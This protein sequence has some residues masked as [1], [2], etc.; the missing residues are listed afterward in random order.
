[1]RH[2]PIVLQRST[3]LSQQLR[4][5]RADGLIDRQTTLEH[6][7]ELVAV[8]VVTVVVY[9]VV[10]HLEGRVAEPAGLA[11]PGLDCDEGVEDGADAPD[12]CEVGR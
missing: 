2:R 4:R 1:M 11:Q 3:D 7:D 5:P 9:A 8:K 10:H 6:S 12:L